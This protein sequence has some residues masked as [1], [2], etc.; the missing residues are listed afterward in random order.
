[1][2]EVPVLFVSHGAA[3]LTMDRAQPMHH[4]LLKLG[5]V[6]RAWRPRS[7]LVISAH[8]VRAAFTVA[9]AP[10]ISMI[11]DHPAAAGR[12]WSASGASALAHDAKAALADA[13]LE[14]SE[15][16]PELDH[17]AWVPLSLLFPQGQVPIA[18]LSLRSSF[19]PRQH[20]RA[21]AA[22][23]PL[24]VQGVLILAS[25]G[26]T[27]NQRVFR[28]GYLSG[29]SADEQVQPFSERFDAWVLAQLARPPAARIAS[30]LDAQSHPDFAQAHPSLDHWLPLVVAL[31]AAG[32]SVS[33][34]LISGFQ[35]SLSMRAVS[36][37]EFA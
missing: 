23:A 35:H 13:G 22:L 17:G 29:A 30:V 32:E 31:G 24:R 36:F 2:S 1:M 26:L 5:A 4:R 11:A 8:D 7:V 10:V 15:G 33:R 37:G 25:G 21:G 28:E 16:V 6:V 34:A 19:D 18:T 27:H 9:S 14:V 20:L 3:S 12:R